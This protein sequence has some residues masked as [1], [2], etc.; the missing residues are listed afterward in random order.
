[1]KQF[2]IL[3]LS[4]FGTDVLDELLD[5]GADVLIV[6]RDRE[7]IDLYKDKSVNAVAMDVMNE[8]N[9]ARV[10]PKKLD[11]VVIDMGD[12][13]EG[14][15]LATSY[16]RKLG[17]ARIFVKA[18]TAGH[19]EILDL[20]GATKVVFPNREAAK[21]VTPLLV[22]AGLL[23]YVPISGKLVIAELAIPG[24]FVGKSLLEANLRRDY[25]INLISVKNGEDSEYGL[26]TPE[27][28]FQEGDTALVSGSDEALSRFSDEHG[29]PLAESLGMTL[30][31]LFGKK[32]G[33]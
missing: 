32:N 3:G 22:S 31:R 26:F 10:L 25:G 28:R 27:Y 24:R 18:V 29:K 33:K 13:I 30:K 1:M 23:N 12:N 15:I 21:R 8:A 2:A 19:A 5:M 20:V 7:V 6:D 9:L 11:G 14:S 17:V 16:C 4:Q